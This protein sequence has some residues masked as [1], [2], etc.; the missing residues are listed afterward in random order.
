[1]ACT[2]T[3]VSFW[4][5]LKSFRIWVHGLSA[6][7]IGGAATTVGAHLADPA[8]IDFSA[9]GFHAI[10]KV[11]L[12]GGAVLACAYLVKSPLPQPCSQEVK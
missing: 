4:D 7:C 1:M 5:H 12:A 2:I 10:W 6:A 9:A 11:A 3:P 8:H